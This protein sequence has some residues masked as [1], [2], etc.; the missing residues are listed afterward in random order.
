MLSQ[1]NVSRKCSRRQGKQQYILESRQGNLLLARLLKPAIPAM[2]AAGG[3]WTFPTRPDPRVDLSPVVHGI[4]LV[5]RPKL[6]CRPRSN[7]HIM[8][9]LLLRSHSPV[10]ELYQAGFTSEALP[11]SRR[12]E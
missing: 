11:L 2:H 3:F 7:A 10:S 9:W 5:T 12:T 8:K 6:Q 4:S 1:A